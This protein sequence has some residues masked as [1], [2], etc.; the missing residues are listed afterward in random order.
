MTTLASFVQQSAG[1][2]IKW[3]LDDLGTKAVAKMTSEMIYTRFKKDNMEDFTV[4]RSENKGKFF[5]K[6]TNGVFYYT[7]EDKSLFIKVE[8]QISAGVA[9]IR[10]V[11]VSPQKL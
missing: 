10:V 11:T 5:L 6:R 2:G 9:D 8:L 4:Y 3:D 1:V 7:N